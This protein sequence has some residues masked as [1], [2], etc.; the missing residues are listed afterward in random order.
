MFTGPGQAGRRTP[1][2][3][4]LHLQ[5]VQT[6]AGLTPTGQRSWETEGHEEDERSMP[7]LDQIRC[8][9][10]DEIKVKRSSSQTGGGVLR[11][12]G[13]PQSCQGNR[14]LICLFWLCGGVAGTAVASWQQLRGGNPPP[15]HGNFRLCSPHR[16]RLTG[17]LCVKEHSH[18]PLCL[19]PA[20]GAY[21]PCQHRTAST[22]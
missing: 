6:A 12:T 19:S 22:R 21:L 2:T 5:R 14:L 11:R 20:T 15:R 16:P 13:G 18:L 4:S 7:R 10:G 1:P 9:H 8:R 17:D 3:P